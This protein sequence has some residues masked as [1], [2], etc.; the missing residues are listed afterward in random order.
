EYT[1]VEGNLQTM[2]VPL[3]VEEGEVYIAWSYPGG[4][5]CDGDGV[6]ERHFGGC[7]IGYMDGH[8]ETRKMPPGMTSYD[9]TLTTPKG[10]LSFGNVGFTWESGLDDWYGRQ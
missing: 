2:D 4:S 8:A 3:F 1:D 10:N 5:W 7:S 6:S 9:L